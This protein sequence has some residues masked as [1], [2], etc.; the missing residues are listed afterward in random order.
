MTGFLAEK[1]ANAKGN[2][3]NLADW[4]MFEVNYPVFKYI[5]TPKHK[6]RAAS[7]KRNAARFSPLGNGLP[8]LSGVKIVIESFLLDQFLVAAGFFDLPFVNNK[9]PI[10][11]FNRR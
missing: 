1:L 7:P 5:I 11:V 4:G 6:N 8:C 10:A 9:N 2:E 3:I